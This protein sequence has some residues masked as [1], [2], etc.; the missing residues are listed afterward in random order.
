MPSAKV[1]SKSNN[2]HQ[3]LFLLIE[4][5]SNSS[6]DEVSIT[7]VCLCL[8]CS[9]I[10]ESLAWFFFSDHW[11]RIKIR[12]YTGVLAREFL[13]YCSELR[14]IT[15]FDH[16]WTR[17]VGYLDG[18]CLNFGW[19]LALKVRVVLKMVIHMLVHLHW[20]ER[21]RVWFLMYNSI[22]FYRLS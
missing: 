18:F 21:E 10:T 12:T 19:F 6:K 3:T 15:S 8:M 11:T 17:Y 4:T 20:S 14:C 5:S 1:L 9:V 22:S 16:H 7:R 13:N 2:L